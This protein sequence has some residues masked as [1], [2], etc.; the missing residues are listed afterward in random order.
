M[1]PHIAASGRT[2]RACCEGAEV[3]GVHRLP[4]RPVLG[5]GLQYEGRSLAFFYRE[6]GA[7]RNHSPPAMCRGLCVLSAKALYCPLS[8]RCASRNGG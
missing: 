8:D 3:G 5:E 2:R 4:S 7:E 1:S 6:T